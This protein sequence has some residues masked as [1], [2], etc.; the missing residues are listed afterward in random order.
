MQRLFSPLFLSGC[1]FVD[2]WVGGAAVSAGRLLF[3]SDPL[4]VMQSIVI[5][6]L[7]HCKSQNVA[8]L[9]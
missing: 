2:F 6:L 4:P 7:P 1:T 9:R 5:Y 3:D 8:S